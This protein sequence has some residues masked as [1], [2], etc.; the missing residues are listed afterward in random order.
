MSEEEQTQVLPWEDS[1]A[2]QGEQSQWP[3]RKSPGGYG[4]QFTS[5]EARITERNSQGKAPWGRQDNAL[6][7]GKMGRH[8]TKNYKRASVG[9]TNR[10]DP[11]RRKK[12]PDLPHTTPPPRSWDGPGA[13]KGLASPNSS[14]MQIAAHPLLKV[15]VCHSHPALPICFQPLQGQST[16]GL[17]LLA[18]SRPP[19][20]L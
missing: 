8:S 13:G 11:R 2:G 10:P 14:L 15:S 6:K 1:Q 5:T 4:V 9:R 20:G 19:W 18:P 17:A 3:R 16:A 7:S 12:P